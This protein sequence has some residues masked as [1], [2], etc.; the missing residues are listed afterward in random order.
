MKKYFLP[1]KYFN[2]TY[3]SSLG[4]EIELPGDVYRAL[5]DG[6]AKLEQFN[7]FTPENSEDFS[8]STQIS[9]LIPVSYSLTESRGYK[10]GY[11][12]DPEF[13]GY[14]SVTLYAI[15]QELLDYF[16]SLGSSFMFQYG[17]GGGNR[18]YFEDEK[19]GTT[20]YLAE[21]EILSYF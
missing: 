10:K 14:N 11:T 15:T 3:F 7:C 16:K 6:V 5:S 1:E 4:N 19:T 12:V 9:L 13:E 2:G 18:V 20:I 17:A 21:E 8:V